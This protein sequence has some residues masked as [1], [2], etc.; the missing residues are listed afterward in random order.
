MVSVAGRE[1]VIS[2]EEISRRA[3]ELIERK[4]GADRLEDLARLFG[5]SD[6]FLKAIHYKILLGDRNFA[7]EDVVHYGIA[8][9][10]YSDAIKIFKENFIEQDSSADSTTSIARQ[11]Q[12]N[13]RRRENWAGL[14]ETE[15]QHVVSD[16]IEA[17]E[18]LARVYLQ[19]GYTHYGDAL[20]I[21][22]RGVEALN[23]FETQIKEPIRQINLRLMLAA[24][25]TTAH[26]FSG[27]IKGALELAEK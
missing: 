10:T 14:S 27:N 13:R 25:D 12:K 19:S 3:G 7:R 21:V 8:I 15:T 4:Y 16:F 24:I 26:R 11:E 20:E 2:D 18:K 9:N 1:F 6:N 22:G 5:G 17:H 23:R